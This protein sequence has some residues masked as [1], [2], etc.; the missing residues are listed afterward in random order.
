MRKTSPSERPAAQTPFAKKAANVKAAKPTTSALALDLIEANQALAAKPLA[1]GEHA[2]RSVRA[3]GAPPAR[4][5]AHLLS[6]RQVL[7]IANVSY[8]TLWA[9][10][11]AGTFPRS[12]VVGGKSMWLSTDIEAWLAALPVRQLKGDEPKAARPARQ[13]F[14]LYDGRDLLAIIACVAATTS[15]PSRR[16]RWPSR[17]SRPA[18]RTSQPRPSQ[19]SELPTRRFNALN[20]PLG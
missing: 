9:W 16:A 4:L 17:W 8:P 14:W 18:N 19:A 7:A 2:D 1:R 12:R 20:Q 15:A 13:C 10:M 5:G 6:K 3:A 11:R